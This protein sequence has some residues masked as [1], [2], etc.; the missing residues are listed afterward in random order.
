MGRV[1]TL[2]ER[3]ST[4][5]LISTI[6]HP[7]FFLY[8]S[9]IMIEIAG[10]LAGGRKAIMAE[11]TIPGWHP[12]EAMIDAHCGFPIRMPASFKPTNT[13]AQ[14][15]IASDKN[16]ILKS[17]RGNDFERLPTHRESTMLCKV[18]EKV[19]RSRDLMSFAAYVWL[20]GEAEDVKRDALRA[21]EE[22]K[23]EVETTE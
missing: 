6:P 13:A 4:A 17:V 8:S 20:I 23:V 15:Y 7:H 11:A 18:G 19:T 1:S 3:E 21:R 16:G 12:F 22:F 14:A 10:R 5:P 2:R 9:P